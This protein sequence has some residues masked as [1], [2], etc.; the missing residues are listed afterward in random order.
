MAWGVSCVDTTLNKS[1]FS[2]GKFIGTYP[3]YFV[4][5][6]V[7]LT[8]LCMTGWVFSCDLI[9][10]ICISQ[11]SHYHFHSINFWH[12]VHRYQQLKYEIDPEY[13]FSPVQGAGKIERAI[14]EKNFKVNY[15]SRFSV[16][17]ITRP[18]KCEQIFVCIEMWWCT[19]YVDVTTCRF[20]CSRN[21]YT[22]DVLLD[23]N[24]MS[25]IYLLIS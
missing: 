15:T 5:I 6:P 4:I 24:S 21:R 22:I 7:L 11:P 16:G 17:R 2:L 3:G 23:E 12:N 9:E 1:F 18:G 20:S 25:F 10:T 14:V 19:P 8:F 13:L